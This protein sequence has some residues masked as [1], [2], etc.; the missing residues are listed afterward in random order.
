MEDERLK[1]FKELIDSFSKDGYKQIN[2]R[3]RQQIAN[4]LTGKPRFEGIYDNIESEIVPVNERQKIADMLRNQIRDNLEKERELGQALAQLKISAFKLEKLTEQEVL[5][6]TMSSLLDRKPFTHSKVREAKIYENNIRKYAK[7]HLKSQKTISSVQYRISKEMYELIKKNL[8]KMVAVDF[9]NQFITMN[10]A[11]EKNKIDL[12]LGENVSN[13]PL[14][15]ISKDVE[16]NYYGEYPYSRNIERLGVDI[17][18]IED[19]DRLISGE[20]NSTSLTWQGSIALDKLKNIEIAYN[21]NIRTKGGLAK[22]QEIQKQCEKI[23]ELSRE[24]WY[25]DIILKAFRHTSIY[26]SQMYKGLQQLV[27]D[28]NEELS[29]LLNDVNKKYDK[30][31]LQNKLDLVEQLEEMYIELK[32]IEGKITQYETI[33]KDKQEILARRDYLKLE[34][35]MIQ[36][37]K[38]N[39]DLNNPKYNINIDDIIEKEMNSYDLKIKNLKEPNLHTNDNV[40]KV[41]LTVSPDSHDRTNNEAIQSGVSQATITNAD[42]FELDS[43]TQIQRTMHYQNYMR[44]KVLNT[45]LGKLS[46]SAYLEAIAPHLVKLINIEKEREK[47]ARTIYKDY[48]KYYASLENKAAAIEFSEFAEKNYGIDKIDV[49]VEN[50]EEYS[51]MIRR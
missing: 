19:A 33:Q 31:G 5:L 23:T 37:L 51:G 25:V 49:P 21:T 41:P 34:Y 38:E 20:L 18:I 2:Q 22:L 39:P 15:E 30:T 45:D 42:N 9:D 40:E 11:F 32:K 28:Q 47:F 36:I 24:T 1:T 46:F 12:H 48:I 4:I 35:Q 43:T 44:E 13:V 26:E 29:R 6:R 14:T 7:L 27:K 16:E 50:M 17:A 3:F 10:K 8:N